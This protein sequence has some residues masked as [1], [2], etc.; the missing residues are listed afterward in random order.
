[1]RTG[2]ASHKC[3]GSKDQFTLQVLQRDAPVSQT[4][5]PNV[6]ITCASAWG[7]AFILAALMC[8]RGQ[9]VCRDVGG[10]DPT[11][12]FGQTGCY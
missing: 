1:M 6:S 4:G 9:C 5:N 10:R 3:M 11:L 12:L 7:K 8:L 2:D